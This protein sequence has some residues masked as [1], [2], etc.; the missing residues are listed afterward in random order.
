MLSTAGKYGV[1]IGSGSPGI[2]FS[3]SS[4]YFL[5]MAS[6]AV[7]QLSPCSVSSGVA[8]WASSCA[9]SSG[10]ALMGASAEMQTIGVLPS[11]GKMVR[12]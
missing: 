3:R 1:T 5:N 4:L 9:S 8:T 2:S 10:A 12:P 7:L 6:D 11:S